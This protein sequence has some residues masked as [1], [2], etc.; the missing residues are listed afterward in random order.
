MGRWNPARFLFYPR[1]ERG[2]VLEG[3]AE[4]HAV[5]L[6]V[7]VPVML[8]LSLF[9][10]G[11]DIVALRFGGPRMPFYWYLGLD[12]GLLVLQTCMTFVVFL[13][14]RPQSGARARCP[15]WLITV[16]AAL[17]LLWAALVSAMEMGRTGNA[18]TLVITVMAASMLLLVSFVTFSALVVGSVA[19]FIVAML[20]LPQAQPITFERLMFVVSLV[21][22][23]IVVSRSLFAA[24]VESILARRR[25]LALNE[26]LRAA[27]SSVVQR[28][29]LATIGRLSAGIIHEI[30]NPLGFLK[31]NIS[32]L[33]QHFRRI[34]SSGGHPGDDPSYAHVVSIMDRVFDDVNEGFRRIAEVTENLR[35]FTRAPAAGSFGSCDL[36]RSLE[37]ALVVSRSSWEHVVRIEKEIVTVPPVEARESEI[38]QVLLN[39]LLNA[40][41]A[42]AGAQG[43]KVIRVRTWAEAGTVSCDVSDTGPGVPAALRDRIFEPFF[44]THAAGDGLGLGL[45]L[46]WEIVVN[47]HHGSLTLLEGMPTTFRVTLPVRQ[48]TG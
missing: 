31:G 16:Y 45:S 38:T 29:K 27:Q 25:L 8:L 20:A 33:E 17:C 41:R 1:D 32:M 6:R 26:E 18:T 7:L 47:R 3:F 35:G 34:V 4:L 43:E 39:L 15:R 46:S 24:H 37:S 21:V 14:L 48:P 10:L 36:N 5:R 40:A 42:V 13:G 11:S 19:V 30:N 9:L 23:S 2:P 28:E 12:T 22:I 44:T